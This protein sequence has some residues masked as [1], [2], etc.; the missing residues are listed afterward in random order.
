ML[1]YSDKAEDD[2]TTMCLSYNDA[3]THMCGHVGELFKVPPPPGQAEKTTS[4]PRA[5]QPAMPA[6]LSRCVPVPISHAS[7]TPVC[8]RVPEC[9]CAVGTLHVT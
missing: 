1:R 5:P 7:A 4:V 3:S 2:V 9:V 8:F 6:H